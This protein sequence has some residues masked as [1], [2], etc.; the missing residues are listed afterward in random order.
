M[1]LSTGAL[2][3]IFAE[4]TE[5]DLVALM[6]ITGGGLDDP[7]YLADNY[8]TTEVLANGTTKYTFV[9]TAHTYLALPCSVKLPTQK[10]KQAPITQVTFKNVTRELMPSIRELDGSETNCAL[11]IVVKSIPDTVQIAMPY[12]KLENATYDKDTLSVDLGI[13]NFARSK[14][15]QYIIGPEYFAGYFS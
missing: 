15:I 9:T 2:A 4:S 11:N 5:D 1:T 3:M 8:N 12:F 6:T 13:E 14:F 10:P 7:I